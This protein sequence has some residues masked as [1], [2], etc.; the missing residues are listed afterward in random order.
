MVGTS[1]RTS[2]FP[3]ATVVDGSPL[4]H[5]P[6]IEAGVPLES[7]MLEQQTRQNQGDAG[8]VD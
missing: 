3:V 7:H 5:L 1:I 4:S 6:R 8:K 2:D